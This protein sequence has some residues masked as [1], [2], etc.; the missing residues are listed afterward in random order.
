MS[1]NGK[2]GNKE[3]DRLISLIEKVTRLDT[4]LGEFCRQYLL[5]LADIKKLT[6]DNDKRIEELEKKC[7]MLKASFDKWKMV[8]GAVAIIVVP[9]LTTIVV[10]V[11]HFLVGF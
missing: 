7:I 3:I 1:E 8:W 2:S 5:D 4:K 11:I 10:L 9:I 6:N